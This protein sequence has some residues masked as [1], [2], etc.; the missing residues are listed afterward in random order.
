MRKDFLFKYLHDK[1][2]AIEG[3]ADK[4]EIVRR[5]LEVWGSS[6]DVDMLFEDE[7]SVDGPPPAPVPSRNASHTSLCSLDFLPNA[8]ALNRTE[9]GLRRCES[10]ASIMNFDESSNSSFT[11]GSSHPPPPPS[12]ALSECSSSLPFIPL[13]G[14]TP[15]TSVSAQSQCQEMANGF[16]KWFYDL[17]NTCSPGAQ[18]SPEFGPAMFW[19]DAS[20]KV[21]L[22]GGSGESLES[23][24]VK[25]QTTKKIV[26]G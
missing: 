12:P 9:F 25:L 22:L 4:S 8:F 18:L 14:G 7:N 16:V 15:A 21:N 24:Q 11:F 1:K 23:F 19:A 13:A 10:N 26:G 6:E 3:S 20:A 5:V 17:I 2:I